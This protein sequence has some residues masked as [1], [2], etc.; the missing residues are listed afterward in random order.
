MCIMCKRSSYL[1]YDVTLRDTTSCINLSHL[2]RIAS[3]PEMMTEYLRGISNIL[4]ITSSVEKSSHS[5]GDSKLFWH[6]LFRNEGGT[7]LFLKL[8]HSGDANHFVLPVYL[9][10]LPPSLPLSSQPQLAA[11]LL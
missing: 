11:R 7:L 8:S 9:L 2:G 4:I 3:W 1:S 10:A 6:R 5:L